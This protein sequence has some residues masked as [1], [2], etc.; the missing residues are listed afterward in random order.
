MDLNTLKS[1]KSSSNKTNYYYL[2]ERNQNEKQKKLQ[3]H[4]KAKLKFIKN[5]NT[6]QMK[7]NFCIKIKTYYEKETQQIPNYFRTFA[8][9]KRFRLKRNH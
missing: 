2:N 4:A 3:T 1:I 5:S 8:L 7:G 9:A 6:I